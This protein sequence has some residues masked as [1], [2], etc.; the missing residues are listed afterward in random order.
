MLQCRKRFVS[1]F[2]DSRMEYDLLDVAIQYVVVT[3]IPV[4]SF[5]TAMQRKFVAD[6]LQ[7]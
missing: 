6:D 2:A 3:V 7:R 5:S 4:N 1:R